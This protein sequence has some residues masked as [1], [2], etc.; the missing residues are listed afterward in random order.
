MGCWLATFATGVG[1]TFVTAIVAAPDETS[2]QTLKRPVGRERR[3]CTSRSAVDR[4]NP[5]TCS[6]LTTI[7]DALTMGPCGCDCDSIRSAA[8]SATDEDAE[9]LAALW[10]DEE[11]TAAAA[12]TPAIS[13]NTLQRRVA[14]PK[15][16]AAPRASFVQLG[17][18]KENTAPRGATEDP[19]APSVEGYTGLNVRNRVLSQAVLR[20][21][22]TRLAFFKLHQCE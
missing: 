21:R 5:I 17:K 4:E 18:G 16:A 8:P 6:F 7:P 20:D 11:P 9:L 1:V 19:S 15:P 2:W 13:T 22:F 12:A 10:A 3:P 14:A